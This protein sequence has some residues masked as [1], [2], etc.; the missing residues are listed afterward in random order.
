M[1]NEDAP[2]I[3]ISPSGT[4]HVINYT[5]STRPVLHALRISTVCGFGIK[6]EEALP[7]DAGIRDCP[8]CAAEPWPLRKIK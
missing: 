3:V 7:L 5:P 4:R 1:T 2:E 8:F 6:S